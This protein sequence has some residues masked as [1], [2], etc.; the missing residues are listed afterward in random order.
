MVITHRPAWIVDAALGNANSS[1]HR[2]AKR[3][4]VCCMLAGH[5]HQ[6]IHADLDGVTYFAAPSAGGHLRLSGKYEDG[7]FFGWTNVEVKGSEVSF[8]VHSLDGKSTPLSA[9]GR[10]GLLPHQ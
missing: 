4:G 1:L 6:L 8:R 9:W 10:A 2:L 7:W 3:Y 5:V